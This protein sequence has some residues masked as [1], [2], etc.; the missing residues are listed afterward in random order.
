MYDIVLIESLMR[1]MV[2]VVVTMKTLFCMTNV[3]RNAT[4]TSWFECLYYGQMH[5]VRQSCMNF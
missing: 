2:V 4:Q 3:K 5:V 1:S